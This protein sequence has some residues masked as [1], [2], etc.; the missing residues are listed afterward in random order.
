MIV[1]DF[2]VPPGVVVAAAVQLV[3]ALV[4]IGWCGGAE[5]MRA[6]LERDQEARVVALVQRVREQGWDD[7]A[8]DVRREY[9]GFYRW[10]DDGSSVGEVPSS[11]IYGFWE[12]E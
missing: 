12:E 11:A 6:G 5:W 7:G 3:V 9:G 4:V 8:D 2:G 10:D 1:V